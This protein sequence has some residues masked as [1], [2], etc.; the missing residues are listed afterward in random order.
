[1]CCIC[2]LQLIFN[3]CSSWIKTTPLHVTNL[4]TEKGSAWYCEWGLHS[5]NCA[6]KSIGTGGKHHFSI[7]TCRCCVKA[8]NNELPN[9]PNIPV[10]PLLWMV[11]D[12][13]VSLS[14]PSSCRFWYW[15][16]T[17]VNVS[18]MSTGDCLALLQ[19]GYFLPQLRWFRA[20]VFETERERILKRQTSE[21]FNSNDKNTIFI[22]NLEAYLH[23]HH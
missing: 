7:K 17:W 4:P 19:V 13:A 18:S 10:F 3:T 6:C 16:L 2:L 11:L 8:D 21:I 23:L 14:Q 20:P 12:S 15:G 5:L 22:V 9:E 1:M